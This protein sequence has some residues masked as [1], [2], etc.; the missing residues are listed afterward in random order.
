MQKKTPNFGCTTLNSD[1]YILPCEV[2]TEKTVEW[3]LC[4][5]FIVKCL[6]ISDVKQP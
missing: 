1:P 4:Y 5:I 2:R 6:N 3:D